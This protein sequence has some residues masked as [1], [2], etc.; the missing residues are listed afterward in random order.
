VL[1]ILCL[2]PR[3]HNRRENITDW[4]L[5]QFRQVYGLEVTKWDIFHY[6]YALLHDQS[7]APAT[8]ENLKRELPRIP[9]TRRT[10][11]CVSPLRSNRRGTAATS[12]ELRAAEEYRSM[13]GEPRRAVLVGVEKMRLNKERRR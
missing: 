13:V 12:P 1:P 11:R 2:R 7:T 8:A 4:A 10:C 3:R 9:L 5:D 6:T